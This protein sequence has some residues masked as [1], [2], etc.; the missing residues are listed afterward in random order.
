MLQLL[1]I[2]KSMSY[3]SDF[4][5]CVEVP[6]SKTFRLALQRLRI[7]YYTLINMFF[8]SSNA[9]IGEQ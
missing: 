2:S 7:S 1:L 6:T 9:K 5:G 4:I 8:V 3:R